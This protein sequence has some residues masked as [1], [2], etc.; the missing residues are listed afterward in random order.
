[1]K[2][3]KR[4]LIFFILNSCATTPYPACAVD[5]QANGFQC[6]R[7]KDK[8]GKQEAWFMPMKEAELHIFLLRR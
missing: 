1:M 5:L 8:D 6:A 4:S 3:L 2:S 7:P